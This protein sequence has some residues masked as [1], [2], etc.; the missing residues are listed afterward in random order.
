[1]NGRNIVL[2]DVGCQGV[3]EQSNNHMCRY[4]RKIGVINSDLVL[5]H[6]NLH[7]DVYVC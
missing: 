1:V 2:A 3:G 4:S 5:L 7:V 6:D